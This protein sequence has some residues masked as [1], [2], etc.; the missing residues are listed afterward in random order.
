MI[1]GRSGASDTFERVA[2]RPDRIRDFR[3]GQGSQVSDL[4]SPAQRRHLPEKVH[5]KGTNAP[6][7][8]P[9]SAAQPTW[10]HLLPARADP[11]TSREV[12]ST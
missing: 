11:L 2:C 7:S 3:V 6:N 1:A 8:L 10:Q 5:C 9:P 4:E 12:V